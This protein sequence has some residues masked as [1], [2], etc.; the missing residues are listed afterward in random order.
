MKLLRLYKK[1]GILVFFI[2]E[3]AVFSILSPYFLTSGNIMMLLRQVA[4]LGI[5]S[6][7]V[8]FVMLG[9]S[10][11]DLSIAGQIP[12]LTMIN[13]VMMKWM[14]V[15]PIVAMV[16]TVLLGIS[17]GFIN[18]LVIRILKINP[19]VVTLSTMTIFSGVALMFTGG[20]SITGLPA[21]F[22]W[23]GQGYVWKIPVPII[24]LFMCA[25]V[26]QFV[27]S[28]TYFGRSLYCMGGNAEAARLAGINVNRV[29]VATFMI[30]GFFASISSLMIS[31]RTMTASPTAGANYAF[32]TMTACVLGGVSFAGGEGKL[33]GA[34]VG[35]LVIGALSNAMTLLNVGDYWQDIIKGLILIFALFLDRKQREIT[36]A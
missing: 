12:V 5:A 3:M 9:G 1:A 20:T 4:M 21:G 28:K 19:F 18:G 22:A 31:S 7:G 35:A 30:S 15:P 32:D 17:I 14:G 26:A 23:L 25:A 36:A 8:S 10:S 16:I 29:R 24:V 33:W 11:A 13:A 34:F 2:I 6:I 27:L